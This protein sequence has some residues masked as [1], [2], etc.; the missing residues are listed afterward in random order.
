[1]NRKIDFTNKYKSNNHDEDN[2]NNLFNRMVANIKDLYPGKLTFSIEESAKILSISPQ[3]LYK[4]IQTGNIE[5]LSFG[6]RKLI[7]IEILANLLTY[8]VN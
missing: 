2:N 4:K 6:D 7:N 1:M 8:G 5:A 3:F